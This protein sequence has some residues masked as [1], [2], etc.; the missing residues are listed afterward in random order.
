DAGAPAD[1]GYAKQG[2][3]E[4]VICSWFEPLEKA[5]QP[6]GDPTVDPCL[7]GPKAQQTTETPRGGTVVGPEDA[8]AA[9]VSTGSA[10]S[11]LLI[12]EAGGQTDTLIGGAGKFDL[13]QGA[14]GRQRMFGGAGADYL[15][16]E[17]G[18][19]LLV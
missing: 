1:I 19:D 9:G 4:I 6:N 17:R 18:A 2:R 3:F 16:G 10:G 14:R 13:L 15:T 11:E 8:N 7:P 12:A 5:D